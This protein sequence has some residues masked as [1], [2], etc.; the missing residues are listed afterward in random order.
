M[1][2]YIRFGTLLSKIMEAAEIRA[3]QIAR[4]LECTSAYITKLKQ[5]NALPN[6]EQLQKI[7][8][9][10]RQAAVN[11]GNIEQLI[12][13]YT[14][15]RT[16]MTGASE[17]TAAPGKVMDTIGNTPELRLC[18]KDAM[19]AK[20]L[21]SAAELT[22]YIGYDSVHTIERLLNGKLNWF[23][24]VLSSV[25]EALDISQD[26]IPV[27]PAERLLL[28]PE[29]MFR[30]GG[31]LVRPLPVVDW[32]NAASHLAML[33]NCDTAVLRKWDPESVETI[34]AP[35]GTRKDTQVFR[36]FG[37]SMEPTICD[38]EIIFCE[39][40]YRLDDIGNGKI[41]VV[42]FSEHSAN[43]GTIVCKRFRKEKDTIMLSS[44]NARDGKIF[45]GITPRDIAWIGTVTQKICDVL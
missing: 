40:Q 27:T 31:V 8:N 19:M 30:N 29:G 7:L 20:G 43:P 14:Q 13:I 33:E 18:I 1:N 35:V 32:A 25:L 17:G 10:F 26:D 2:K 34:A 21:T 23:P 24:D 22:K 6:P 45:T 12:Q 44:D 15:Y 36:I 42:K 16:G 3:V 28:L 5:G 39:P 37:E 41:V 38:G 4:L 9:C 11:E